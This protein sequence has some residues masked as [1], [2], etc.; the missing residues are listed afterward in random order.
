M[1]V[2]SCREVWVHEEAGT[3]DRDALHLFVLEQNAAMVQNHETTERPEQAV[4]EIKN[5]RDSSILLNSISMQSVSKRSSWRWSKRISSRIIIRGILIQ[6]ESSVSMLSINSNS[7]T[8][9]ARVTSTAGSLA[10]LERTF[11]SC[12]SRLCVCAR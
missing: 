4:Q 5:H 12:S 2:V 6:R 8:R 11:Q 1:V 3:E 9:C 10:R 7:A